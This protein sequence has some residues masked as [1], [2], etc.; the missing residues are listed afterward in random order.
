MR[1]KQAETSALIPVGISGAVKLA[2]PKMF[3]LTCAGYLLRVSA[4]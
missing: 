4:D 1:V 2:K 3:F